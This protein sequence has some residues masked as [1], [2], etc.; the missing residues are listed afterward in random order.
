MVKPVF[1][2][3]TGR[4]R[5]T[6]F[7]GVMSLLGL[8]TVTVLALVGSIL[9][10]TP[11]NGLDLHLEY[12]RPRAWHLPRPHLTRS[13]K[14]PPA[15]P[16]GQNQVNQQIAGFYV[17]WDDSSRVSLSKHIDNIDIL[18]PVLATVTGADHNFVYKPD[19]RMRAELA[20]ADRKPAVLTVVQNAGQARWDG[21]NLANLFGNAKARTKLLD[22]IEAMIRAEKS[23]G[24]CFDFENLN[25]NAHKRYLAFIVEAR[26]RFAPQGL[27]VSLAVPIDDPDW[28]LKAFAK[29]ADRLVLMAY[30]EHYTDSEPGPIASMAW[31]HTHVADALKQVPP[32]K[33]IV[34]IG[35]YAYD[36]T[37]GKQ[38]A[39]ILSVNEAWLIANDSGS[40]VTF[41][42]VSQTPYF[43]YQ[44]EDGAKHVVWLLDAVSAWNQLRLVDA[45]KASAV[46][47][48][49]MGGE[50]SGVWDDFKHFQTASTPDLAV[51]QSVGN[52][53]V[54]GAGE[55]VHIE[56][57]PH[58]GART[59]TFDK[60]GLAVNEVLSELPTPYVVRR[61]GYKPMTV[62]LTFDDGPD[63]RYTGKI[64]DILKSRGIKATFFVI[65]EKAIN[66]PGLLNRMIAEGHE[67]GNHSYTHPNLAQMPSQWVTFELNSTQRVV[68]AYTGRAMRLMRAPFFGD[69]EPST[70]E[71]LRPVME[72][73]RLGYTS[74]GLHVDSEDWTKPGVAAVIDN[75]LRGVAAGT[76]A[77]K[78]IDPDSG[79]CDGQIRTCRSGNIILMHDS[80]GDRTETIAALPQIIDRLQA[81]GY[82]FV[83]V[84]QLA[85]LSSADAMPTLK[86]AELAQV[87]FDFGVFLFFASLGTLVKWLFVLAIVLGIGRALML[88]SLAIYANYSKRRPR[89]PHLRHG[90]HVS[91]IIPAF[92]E[93]RVIEASVAR[94]LQS[95]GI[96]LEV[97]VVDDGSRDETSAIVTAAF[98][99][100]PRVRLLTLENGG[101]AHAVNQ[102]LKIATG[103][104]VITLDADTQFEPDTIA[105]LVR[106][107]ER[108]EVGAVAGNAKVGNRFNWVTRWQ[109]VE[110]VTAQNLERSALGM[111]EAIMVVPGAVG[112]WRRTA[113]DSVGGYPLNTL[114]E[115]Q[116]LTIAVQRKGWKIAYDQEAVA[117][118]E[119]PESFKALIKQ[120]YRWAFGT[121]QCLWKH[122]A[123][124]KTG[125][126]K[127]LARI[128][129]PQA[130]LFQIAFAV[131][132]PL[133]DFA[134]VVNIIATIVRY[135]QHGWVQAEG[136]TDIW[137]MLTY[138]VAFITI[139]ALCG[140]I[141]YRL[142]P[143]EKT[144]PVWRLISQRFV[145]RQIMYYVVLKAIKSAIDG[146]LVGWNKLDRS[147]R[148]DGGQGGPGEQ[149]PAVVDAEPETAKDVAKVM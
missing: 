42:P 137:R 124:I 85:D 24:V 21:E 123:V 106:W 19:Y 14:A 97:I 122:Q 40:Q 29:A 71:E 111:F 139:D 88:A 84:S 93:A 58:K 44:E 82:K 73:Q 91:V 121:L 22:Q 63:G 87:R 141:A 132:S 142:E 31:F 118:T 38:S 96:T 138:W 43:A 55:I 107:F 120:R 95:R 57:L 23:N 98:A 59:V 60:H 70:D 86:G 2:D 26:K 35:N 89:P 34:A 33:A 17:P 148:M 110:Y 102:G 78:N 112:A 79:E 47:L 64:L 52:V 105:R 10:V 56:D 145:Y 65:G 8:A 66:H 116:D 100:E 131:I 51:L 4:R 90:I 49:R 25:P 13:L 11:Q 54:E 53:P 28:D 129:M 3:P 1:F 127:G 133:I 108:P 36:W 75:T 6:T 16:R 143:L 32:Q 144:Y 77:M 46:A 61:T 15:P 128:G 18:F 48:W 45:T 76:E 30:D 62:A 68:E 119:A 104:I 83:T 37:I 109:A 113:L 99:A 147:G 20:R 135:M 5:K 117:W 72:G 27:S 39:T 101:K 7:V 74:V 69:A 125:K 94:V 146:L 140:A 41:D 103:E 12:E 149:L 92:N 134:L 130:W 115:D 80:G 136:D 81:Q 9:I 50:D 126:P 67:L 114:A